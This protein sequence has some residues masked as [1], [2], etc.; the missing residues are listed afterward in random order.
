LF[1]ER[2]RDDGSISLRNA[3]VSVVIHS[4]WIG[5]VSSWP[6]LNTEYGRL[7]VF[8]GRM[9]QSLVTGSTCNLL[10]KNQKMLQ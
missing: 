10:H 4:Q 7:D 5:V 9:I 1:L 6:T 3:E 2:H 8:N